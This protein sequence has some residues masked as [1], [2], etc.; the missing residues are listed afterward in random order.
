MTKLIYTP[1]GLVSFNNVIEA[2]AYKGD[3]DSPKKFSIKVT[4]EGE[5][6][7][8]FRNVLL[9]LGRPAKLNDGKLDVNFNRAERHG[10]PKIFDKDGKELKNFGSFLPKGTKARIAFKPFSYANGV[11]LLLEAVK[12]EELGAMSGT[13]RNFEV[14]VSG[15]DPAFLDAFM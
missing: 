13:A 10:A 8:N 3:P 11:G 2:Q 15:V 14:D 12:V 5:D 9:E 7:K 4:F 1:T 6:A